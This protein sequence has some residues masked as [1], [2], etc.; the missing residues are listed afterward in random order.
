MQR[1]LGKETSCGAS[2]TGARWTPRASLWLHTRWQQEQLDGCS[3]LF[4]K[5]IINAA[6]KLLF[7]IS[8]LGEKKKK[9]AH[10]LLL[11]DH[12]NS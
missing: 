4:L 9:K 11:G 3:V 10:Y 12:C 5:I 2:G 7:C 8:V 6:F 1:A